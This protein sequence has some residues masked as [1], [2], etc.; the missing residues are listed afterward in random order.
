MVI[1]GADIY[2]DPQLSDLVVKRKRIGILCSTL[3]YV[4]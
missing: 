1:Y 2:K 4:K 3:A